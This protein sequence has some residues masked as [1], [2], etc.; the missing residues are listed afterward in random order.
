MRYVTRVRVRRA[1]EYLRATDASLLQI[2]RLCGY[3][4]DVSLSKA[5]KRVLGISPGRYRQVG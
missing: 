3:G 2:A 1:A 4:S 5:F